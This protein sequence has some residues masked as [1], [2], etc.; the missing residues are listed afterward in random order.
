MKATFVNGT[1]P[2]FGRGADQY[3]GSRRGRAQS[4]AGNI[5]F[6]SSELKGV[7]MLAMDMLSRVEKRKEENRG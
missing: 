4:N 2:S 6:L 7:K 1:D 3:S 5:A